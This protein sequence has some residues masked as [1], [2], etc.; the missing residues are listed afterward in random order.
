MSVNQSTPYSLQEDA[1]QRILPQAEVERIIE[2]VLLGVKARENGTTVSVRSWWTGE[3]RWARNRVSL[4]SDRRDIQVEVTRRILG[5]AGTATTNQL[6]DQSLEAVTISAERSARHA[7]AAELLRFRTIA[8]VLNAPNTIIWS[9]ATYNLATE[10]RAAVA[11]VLQEK[12]EAKALLSAGYIE[13]RAGEIAILHDSNSSPAPTHIQYDTYTQAQCSMT[14]REPRGFGSGWAGLSAYDWGAIDS[15]AL[16][17]TALDKCVRSLNPVAIEPGRYTVILEPQA[18]A[19][20]FEPLFD[21]LNARI[22]AENPGGTF[23]LGPDQAIGIIRSKLGLRV[24]DERITVSHDPNDPALGVLSSPG[25]DAVTWIGKGVL[26]H[27]SYDRQYALEE[28][29]ENLPRSAR[30]SYRISGGTASIPDMIARIKRGLLVTRFSG[31]QLLE[32]RSVLTTGVTRDGLWLIENGAITKAVKNLRFTE[33]P[34]FMLNQVEEI[35]MSIPVF[36][37]VSNPYAPGITDR[38]SVV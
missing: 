5:A 15:A 31:I 26:T 13:M 38:K 10:Q 29:N 24:V 17:T 4:A 25:L 8:P 18:V 3:L 23:T 9:D 37:P 33:S 12:A 27:L 11:R 20:L 36:R 16:A 34:L 2:R 14:V 7:N 35:G 19:D 6:D 21:V 22:P 28:L 32:P 1:N 30:P